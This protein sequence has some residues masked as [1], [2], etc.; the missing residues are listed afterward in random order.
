MGVAVP[1]LLLRTAVNVEPSS[2]TRT[3]QLSTGVYRLV[4]VRCRSC[5]THLGWKYLAA[6]SQEQRYKEG[7]VLL[8]ISALRRVSHPGQPPRPLR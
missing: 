5:H 7:A 2:P 8:G 6:E 4:D 1:A 3:E